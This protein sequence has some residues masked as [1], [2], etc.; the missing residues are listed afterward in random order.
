MPLT[1]RSLT[2]LSR[3]VQL[4]E[5]DGV[6]EFNARLAHIDRGGLAGLRGDALHIHSL[7]GVLGVS[8]GLIVGADT[9]LESL[10]ALTHADVLDAHVDALRHDAVANA[11]VH[12]DADGVSGHVE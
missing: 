11:L 12:D 7:A 9:G 10:T 2:R 5:L 3:S 6:H 8:L 1:I 4:S